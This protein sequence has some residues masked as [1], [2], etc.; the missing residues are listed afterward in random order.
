[1]N[2]AKQVTCRQCVHCDTTRARMRCRLNPPQIGVN[3]L[4]GYWPEVDPDD[5]CA[6]AEPKQAATRRT[7]KAK[8]SKA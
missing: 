4:A 6:R 8:E 1:M 7:R 2:K 5:Y 3:G